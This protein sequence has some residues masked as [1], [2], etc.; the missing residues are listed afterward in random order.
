MA[1]FRERKMIR[2]KEIYIIEEIDFETNL[3]YDDIIKI[4]KK[5]MEERPIP[6]EFYP[7]HIIYRTN[8]LMTDG[9]V[10]GVSIIPSQR[11]SNPAW[12]DDCDE[13]IISDKKAR[14][15]CLLNDHGMLAE[16]YERLS[17]KKMDIIPKKGPKATA[18]DFV[19]IWHE[20]E[21][22]DKK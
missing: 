15:I 14:P 9:P 20:D 8:P 16:V 2:M 18:R 5:F 4:T 13:L 1:K 21:K 6:Y 12:E 17:S 22:K 7:Y 11:R 19:A 10:W 3:K